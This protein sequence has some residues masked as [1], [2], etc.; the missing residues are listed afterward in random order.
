MGKLILNA[1]KIERVNK[2]VNVPNQIASPHVILN[3]RR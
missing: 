3:A 1:A 2:P